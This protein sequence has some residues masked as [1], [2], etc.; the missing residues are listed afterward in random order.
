MGDRLKEKPEK[1]VEKQ[2]D[3]ASTY[4]AQG[5]TVCFKYDSDGN[6]IQWPSQSLDLNP[7]NTYGRF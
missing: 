4:R 2:D 3:K 1:L 6:H 5:I 7:V